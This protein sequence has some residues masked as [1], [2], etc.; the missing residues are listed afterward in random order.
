MTKAQVAG[1]ATALVLTVG[2]AGC[3][4]GGAGERSKGEPSGASA[5]GAVADAHDRTAAA[6]TARMTVATRA[7]AGGEAVTAQGAGVIDLEEGDS[8][9]TLSS[10]GQRIEQRVLDG[11]LYQR[12]HA[13]G[14]DQLPGKK[15]WMKADLSRLKESGSG[16]GGAQVSDPAE[17]FTYTKSLSGREVTKAGTDTI[18]GTRTTHYRVTVD[19]KTLAKGDSAKA[20]QLR[21]QLGTST[22]PLDLWL[23]DKGRLRQ[24]TI[25]LTLRPQAG[26]AETRRQAVT[27]TTTLKFGD[28]GTE[29]D[30]DAPPAR[31]TVDMT[32]K[33]ARSSEPQET[34]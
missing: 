31:D 26:N 29:A 34:A 22:V 7:T 23:D 33:L 18:D 3:G 6:E 27:S 11:V 8:S 21:R 25:R 4:D 15:A 16:G 9:M 12:P 5:S 19:V 24:E 14:R 32:D 28:F 17:P 1:V 10:Q 20:A 13:A 30:I 2:L